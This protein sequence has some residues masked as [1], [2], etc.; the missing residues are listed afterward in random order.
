MSLSHD[1]FA[2]RLPPGPRGRKRIA[3]RSTIRPFP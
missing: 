2:L 1:P 3:A